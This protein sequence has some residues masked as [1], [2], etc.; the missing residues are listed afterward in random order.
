MQHQ[1]VFFSTFSCSHIYRQNQQEVNG[2]NG[3]LNRDSFNEENVE[4]VPEQLDVKSPALEAFSDIFA[5][6][7]LPPEEHSVSLHSNGLCGISL[8]VSL[9]DKRPRAD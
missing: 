9:A 2:P 1:F 8:Y 4:Y 5:R 3:E 6:F 7:Q